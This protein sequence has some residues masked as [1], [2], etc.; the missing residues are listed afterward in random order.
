MNQ[1]MSVMFF[2]DLSRSMRK[3]DIAGRKGLQ[4]IH[5]VVEVLKRFISQQI[6]AGAVMDL[7]SLVTF[8]KSEHQVMF[9]RQRG[10]EAISR[11]ATATFPPGGE[12]KYKEIISAMQG[13]VVP[14]QACRVIFLS[15]GCTGKLESH[16]LP[17]FQEVV[18]QNPYLILHT[19]GFGDC[20]FS[21]LQQLAQIGRGSFSRASM[22]ID[23]LVNT[24]TSLSKTITQTRNSDDNVP[25]R[26]PR[27]VT[28]DSAKRF[29]TGAIVFKSKGAR[30]GKRSVYQLR[31]RELF[32]KSETQCKI[33]LHANPFMQ[34]GMR[35]VYRCQDETI[36]KTMN[37]VAKF[38]R[39]SEDDNSWNYISG[40]VKNAAQTRDFSQ[41]FHNAFWTA[42]FYRT[43][44]YW[45]PRRLVSCNDA[46]VYDLPRDAGR[47]HQLFIAEP[48]LRG[49]EKG[50]LKWVNNRGEIL[51]PPSSSD[52]SMAIEAFAHFSLDQSGGRLMVSD[53]QGV[54]KEGYGNCRR[55][56]L[57]DPQI[58]SLDQSFGAADLGPTAMQTFRSLHVCNALCKRLG[59][60]SLSGIPRA[61]RTRSAV[62]NIRQRPKLP[63][64]PPPPEAPRSESA[65]APRERGRS[66]TRRS[67][68]HVQQ[69]LGE[70]ETVKASALL[71][72]SDQKR[73]KRLLFVGEYTHLFTMAA[74][75]L[76]ST[77][78]QL[79]NLKLEWFSTELRWPYLEPLKTELQQSVDYLTSLGV[80]VRDQVDATAL[81]LQLPRLAGAI[82]AHSSAI[83]SFYLSLAFSTHS[84]DQAACQHD[85]QIQSCL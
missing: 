62:C 76:V 34:G 84:H 80:N 66:P 14:G 10:A 35:L 37:M 43:G 78:L 63:V 33:R 22:D 39:F 82:W 85:N 59:L 40:F 41:K 61:P 49:S 74:A 79:P 17:G 5:A 18:A 7:Y 42:L 16:V 68:A 75:K 38:S 45:E 54:L 60:S 12:V 31:G 24:F 19:I 36:S 13:L 20:D 73:A 25:D 56:H 55:V 81:S 77:R 4:R 48:F 53:L 30:K 72:A 70:F 27:R 32:K 67:G 58:L 47:Q 83:L 29:D 46:W 28:F 57:T 21:I 6:S 52:F 26:V 15:D 50:F 65:L 11:L 3:T 1:S 8:A 69:Q 64:T 44:S 51:V 2:V 23:N 71:L 9:H